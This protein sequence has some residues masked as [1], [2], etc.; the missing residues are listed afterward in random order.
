LNAHEPTERRGPYLFLLIF[1]LLAVGLVT[2]GYSSYRNYERDYRAA[3]EHQLSAIAEL[4]AGELARY[5]KERLGDANII[6]NNP[7][8]SQLVRRFLE[9]PQDAEAPRQ[10]QIWMEKCRKDH[11]FDRVRLLDAQ[12][13]TRLS[14]PA[15]PPAV[16]S[17]VAKDI[18][19]VLRSGRVTFQDFY[20]SDND[21]QIYLGLLVPILDEPDARRPLGVLFLRIDPHDY[22]Y[23]FIQRWPTPSLTAET[24]LVRR[25][26]NDALFLNELRFQTNTALNL[27]APLDR[28]TMPAVQAALGREDVVEGIDYRGVPVVAALRTI[29]DSPWALVA[30]VDAAEV[31]GPMRERLW[32]MVVLIG[33]LIFGAGSGVGLVWRHQR[34]RFYKERAQG[35]AVLQESEARYRALFETSADGILI[36]DLETKVFKQANPALCRMLGYTHEELRTMGVADLHPREDL[37][38]VMAEF[39]A[40]VRGEKTL[41]ADLPCLRKDGTIL[42]ADVN[43]TTAVI[44]HRTCLVGL[45]RDTTE[46]KRAEAEGEKTLWWQQGVNQV[47]QSLLAPASLEDKLKSITDAIVRLFGADFCRIWLIRP[48]DLCERGCVHAGVQEGPHVCRYRDRCLHLLASSGRYTHLDGQA[49]RRVPFG[50]YKIGRVAS[51]EDH[52]FVT[53]DVTND[54]RVHNHE[55][56][57]ELGLVSFAGYQLRI[58]GGETLGVLARFAKHPIPPAEDALLDGLSSTLALAIQ[59]VRAAEALRE[60]DT[61]YRALFAG[62]ADGIVVAD[63]ETTTFRYANPALSRMLGYTEDE[64]R[65]MGV[66]DLHP[67]DAVQSVVAEFEAQARGDKTLAMD[68]PCLRKDGSVV[69]A[70]INSVPITIDGRLCNVGFFRDITERK[71]AQAELQNLHKQLVAASRRAGMAEIATNVL[72]NVGNVLNSVNVSTSLIVEN[73]KKSKASGL[74]RVVV[75]FQEHPHD[76]GAFITNDPRGKHLPAYLAQ[77]SE[78]LLAEQEGNARELDSLRRNVEH[79]KEIVAMQQNYVTFGGVK[80]LIDVVEL[81]EDSLRINAGALSGHRVEVIREFETVPPL[82][83]EKHKIL[84]ILV[85]LLRNAQHAC[86]DSER[87]DKRLT[88][89]VANGEG[90]VR[91]SVMDNGVGIPPENLTRIFNH[92][93]TTRK[94]GHGF[95]LH[96]G[97][98]AAMELGGSLTV[99]SDGPGRGAAFTLELPCSTRENSHE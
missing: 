64:L 79:I 60:S 13:V 24:L 61:R 66:P 98:L 10:L 15:G 51:G 35:A 84:Q 12:G 37:P 7:A 19:D 59:Q 55:W 11:D 18:P 82:N 88:V 53:N 69:Y 41:A 86:Q 9:Q 80:E 48:G 83:V 62:S 26:G 2:V 96:S 46:R 76:L 70:D 52:K 56:A 44:G 81:V 97:A 74:A 72:H 30:R 78:H 8:F 91:I 29:P 90:R 27:R 85:N 16:S 71:R 57:R 58:P 49:H 4:K 20:R 38:R 17:S 77:L 73:V 87:A 99:H 75:L 6:Y 28:V 43:A 1:L 3:A 40:Q 36:A 92:G 89:R 63:I 68:I 67:K 94:D 45:F 33:S 22:L 65:T 50:A 14:S 39:E 47:Q 34:V 32:Q 25:E 21:Q 95:G 5:R 93:F 23:P 42:Y 31:Y 54:P